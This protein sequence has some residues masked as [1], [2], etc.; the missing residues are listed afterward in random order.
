MP[1]DTI[2]T[3]ESAAALRVPRFRYLEWGP[4]I[5]GAVAAAAISFV[6]FTF[7]SALG[8]LGVSP[9]PYRGLQIRP[10]TVLDPPGLLTTSRMCHVLVGK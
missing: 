6:L 2:V 1:A 9:Y 3:T 8:L 7:G 4:V 10:A 5:A